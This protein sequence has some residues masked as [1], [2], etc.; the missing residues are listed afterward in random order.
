M[1]G[2]T[3][4]DVFEAANTLVAEGM[5]PTQE[6]VRV[7]LGRGS[8]GTIHKYLKAWKWACFHAYQNQ[9]VVGDSVGS[10]KWATEKRRLEAIIKNQMEQN[11]KLSLELVDSELENASLKE[12]VKNLEKTVVQ[13][14]ENIL[15]KEADCQA[16][17][18]A[19][20]TLKGERKEVLQHIL[21][22]K[23]QQI[24]S[25]RE[26]I[27][28]LNTE[29]R[30]EAIEAGYKAQEDLMNERVININLKEKIKGLEKTVSDLQQRLLQAQVAHQR[31]KSSG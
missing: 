24:E 14:E 22:D 16:A 4:A 11:E 29:S 2:I 8:K 9:S 10:K 25:L 19:L 7:Y 31:L 3:K 1:I 26:E 20:A 28:V 15:L 12:Q 17:Q 23:N 18:E 27:K 21:G 30:K 6:S 13:N 5:D